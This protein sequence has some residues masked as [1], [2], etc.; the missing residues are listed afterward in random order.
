MTRE[1]MTGR[2]TYAMLPMMRL[3]SALFGGLRLKTYSLV[4][5][6]TLTD[7]EDFNTMVKQDPQ[8]GTRIS[9]KGALSLVLQSTVDVPYDQ[10]KLPTL[11]LQPGEDRMTPKK[12]TRRTFDRLASPKKRYVEIDGCPHFPLDPRYYEE[13]ACEV[14]E[15]VRFSWPGRESIESRFCRKPRPAP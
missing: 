10:W 6:D 11:V 9:L 13:W 7:S 3:C 8:A 1:T 14:E 5:F 4:S 2:L 15:F 12:Y